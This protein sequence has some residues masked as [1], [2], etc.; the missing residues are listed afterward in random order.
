MNSLEP[1]A[2]IGAGCVLPGAANIQ[3]FWDLLLLEKKQFS[4]LNNK[5]WPVDIFYDPQ[6]QSKDSTYSNRAAIIDDSLFFNPDLD[7]PR[8]HQ[9][10]LK[11]LT[12]SIQNIGKTSFTKLRV[13]TILGCMNPGDE[14]SKSLL[15]SKLSSTRNKLLQA[16]FSKDLSINNILAD[17]E[18]WVIDASTDPRVHY[19]TSIAKLANDHLGVQGLAFC[20]DSACASSMTAIDLSCQLLQ[21]QEIDIAIS[22]G[23]EGNLG[24]ET[25]IPFSHLGVLSKNHC[26]PFDSRSDGIVQGEGVVVFAMERLSDA[27]SASHPILGV[28]D[29]ITSSSN[30]SNASLFSPSFENQ[31][32]IYEQMNQNLE[33]NSPHYIEAHGTGTP[34]GDFAELKALVQA[35]KHSASS[36]YLG[37]VKSLIGHTK[38]AAGAAGLLKSLLIIQNRT[39]P[40][41][42]YFKQSSY[43]SPICPL[44]INTSPVNFP[45]GTTPLQIRINSSGFGGANYH[46]SL[47]E[48]VPEKS[49]F[50]AKKFPEPQSISLVAYSSV[51]YSTHITIENSRT[52]KI[53]PNILKKLDPSQT[54]GI[55]AVT[56]ALERS[57]IDLTQIPANR[58][59]VI[60][61]SHTR[62]AKIEDLTES[63]YLKKLEPLFQS[64]SPTDIEK[65]HTM[66]T[67]LLTFDETIC[68][69]INSMTSGRMTHEF[70]THGVNFHIDA[71]FNSKEH[72]FLIAK[73][74]LELG[75]WDLAIVVAIKETPM[76]DPI[77]IERH[78]VSC[79]MFCLKK[80]ALSLSLPNLGE[81]NISGRFM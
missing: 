47:K 57:L 24:L 6:F 79:W 64:A 45:P 80:W 73:N 8:T 41:S 37:S 61:A 74:F 48:F 3:A 49:S 18:S 1:I 68:H 71:D 81:L 42:S 15:K 22:G 62:T 12:E 58:I 38:G 69:S 13:G 5:R 52:Y 16:S 40:P 54:L 11:A 26:L 25:F 70:G 27:L 78:E 76:I 36:I 23:V 46:L 43:D 10:F 50:L 60:S 14:S 59:G 34:V 67:K 17:W 72:S 51:P 56:E 19:P 33:E 66:R 20:A 2:I 44:T 28:I 65:F 21:K 77:Q 75:K 35:F 53:P 7:L 30:G 4:F 32:E 55:L 63:I 29:N 31:K 9:M 39:I